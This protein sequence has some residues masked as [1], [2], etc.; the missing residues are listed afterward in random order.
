M[1][2]A[3]WACAAP[4]APRLHRVQFTLAAELP[5]EGLKLKLFRGAA[6][7]GLPTAETVL[8]RNPAGQTFEGY[9]PRDLWLPSQFLARWEDAAGN[10]L[11]LGVAAGML[12]VPTNVPYVIREEYR[13]AEKA[14]AAAPL[15]V[16]RWAADFAGARL[17]GE[18]RAVP[19]GMRLRE[20]QA[21]EYQGGGPT[22]LGYA[23]RFKPNPAK[24]DPERRF[25][26]LFEF[27]DSVDAAQVRE[28]IEKE[29][30]PALA[31]MP[32]RK[33]GAA[34]RAVG[35]PRDARGE[36]PPAP[37][38]PAA[39]DA[40][41]AAINSIKGIKGWWYAETSNYVILCSLPTG[42]GVLVTRLQTELERLRVAFA[43]AVPPRAPIGAVS[44][45]RVFGEPEEYARHVGPEWA[46][47][48]GLWMP[49]RRELVVS[50]PGDA[51]SKEQNREAVLDVTRHEAFHQYAFYALNACPTS[52][53]FN[54]GHAELFKGAV[55]T[56]SRLLIE[57]DP[58]HVP[59]LERRA[60]AGQAGIA[61]LLKMSYS[62]FYGQGL[63]GGKAIENYAL[64]W[65]LVYY[66]RKGAP[67]ERDRDREYASI[68][69]RYLEALAAAGDPDPA[70]EAAF[71]G[72]DP[73]AFEKAFCEFWLS[74]GAR[75]AARRNAIFTA[76]PPAGAPA[77][78]ATLPPAPRQR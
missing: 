21:F 62:A 48:V 31:T 29:F 44:L 11:T 64:A 65:G 10:R 66:L 72:V 56:Q 70:T 61:A 19:P 42:R 52:P 37:A 75:S 60:R 67:L 77:V 47:S 30:L 16:N 45:I 38:T 39:R 6:P 40:R 51:A 33:E 36:P 34:A 63:N 28:A 26:A 46:A 25:F 57:E 55:V 76:P 32:R 15:D 74:D 20:V 13:G 53:W 43:Q 8:L 54:E 4:A 17:R 58:V 23:F 69:D 5:E 73:A 71:R 35:A 27:R 3:A 68:P 50:A 14:A 7:A 41:E 12:P 22:R 59:V 1:A 49:Q 2:L 78:R 18:P 24:V 9:A